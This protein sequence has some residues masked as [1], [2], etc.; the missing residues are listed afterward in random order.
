MT[1]AIKMCDWPDCLSIE[2]VVKAMYSDLEE[3]G[4]E[5]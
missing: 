2:S 3:T 5:L 4:V 1:R